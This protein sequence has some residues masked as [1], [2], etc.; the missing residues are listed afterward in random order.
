MNASP[1]PHHTDEID[2]TGTWLSIS[3]LMAGILM[4]F[5]LLLISTL[6]QLLDSE[7]QSKSNRIIIIEGLQTGLENAGIESEIDPLTGSLSLS[8]SVLF[9][10][11]R[12]QLKPKGKQFLEKLIPIYSQVIFQSQEISDEVLYLVIEGHSNTGE[13]ARSS[14]S[15]SIRRAESVV[16]QIEKMIFPYKGPFLRKVLP[17]GRGSL[18]VDPNLPAE[19]NRKVLFR[20]EFQSHD[21]AEMI[22]GDKVDK[23]VQ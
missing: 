4:V 17:A 22:G 7:N 18:D 15:L 12:Y 20:F 16:E 1:E 10:G 13:A 8:E 6:A 2:Q 21:F 11:G 9:E 14:M 3:D 23:N 5:T 19:K